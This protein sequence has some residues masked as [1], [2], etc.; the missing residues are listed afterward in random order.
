MLCV[1]ELPVGLACMLAV[2]LAPI[3]VAYAACGQ[4]CMHSLAT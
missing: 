2:G 3:S 4:G 1:A